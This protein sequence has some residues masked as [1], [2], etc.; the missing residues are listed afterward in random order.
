MCRSSLWLLQRS[1][2]MPGGG[3]G[4]AAAGWSR[5]GTCGG[6]ARAFFFFF[7][8]QLL[9]AASPCT[10]ASLWTAVWARVR[11]YPR[12]RVI[13]SR[14]L[15]RLQR[16]TTRG[17][18]EAAVTQTWRHSHN[19]SPSCGSELIPPQLSL[20]LSHR[21]PPSPPLARSTR[22]A[23]CDW[24]RLVE[25]QKVAACKWAQTRANWYT[26]DRLKS[27]C[28]TFPLLDWHTVIANKCPPTHTQTHTRPL[29]ACVWLCV[30]WRR[31]PY[32]LGLFSF[33]F[34]FFFINLP[35]FKIWPGQMG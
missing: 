18:E 16:N 6:F 31:L 29:C 35:L 7:P 13:A 32:F 10:P 12:Q 22:L 30:C 25:Q 2:D 4:G 15:T 14:G 5:G 24:R 34:F 20:P 19:N 1:H 17:C 21:L 8:S 26:A 23:S 33:F 28:L 9:R 11:T 3:A 27:K